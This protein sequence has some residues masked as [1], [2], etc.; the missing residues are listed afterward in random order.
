MAKAAGRGAGL[1]TYHAVRRE[2]LRPLSLA[3][4]MS[5]YSLLSIAGAYFLCYLAF[6]F[7]HLVGDVIQA[8]FQTAA[9]TRKPR[10]G[11]PG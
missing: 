4:V 10:P 11:E 5:G 1:G 3:A 6:L 8:L 2:T 9:N 7:Y